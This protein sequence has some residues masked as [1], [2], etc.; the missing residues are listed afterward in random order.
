MHW[1]GTRYTDMPLFTDGRIKMEAL[2]QSGD[3]LFEQ[4][5]QW[6]GI[7]PNN[8]GKELLER[9]VYVSTKVRREVMTSTHQGKI[10]LGGKFHYIIFARNGGGVYRAFIELTN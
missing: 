9:G 1:I 4:F 3:E 10:I 2:I 8:R 7:K 6:Y 5:Y